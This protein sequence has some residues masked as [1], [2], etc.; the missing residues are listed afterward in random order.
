MNAGERLF[1]TN[2]NSKVEIERLFEIHTRKLWG[3]LD[4]ESLLAAVE[5]VYSTPSVIVLYGKDDSYTPELSRNIESLVD[6]YRRDFWFLNATYDSKFIHVFNEVFNITKQSYPQMLLLNYNPANVDDVDKYVLPAGTPLNVENIENFLNEFRNG[7]LS[8]FIYSQRVPEKDTDENGI[9]RVVGNTYDD[10]VL[11]NKGK[12]VL[13]F[14]C[15]ASSKKCKFARERYVRVSKKL[16]GNSGL[17]FTEIETSFN[18][19]THIKYEHLPTVALIPGYDSLNERTSNVKVFDGEFYTNSIVE[20]VKANARTKITNE[21]KLE[22]ELTL[23]KQ[24]IKK[25]IKPVDKE[26]EEDITGV[27]DDNNIGL[28]RAVIAAVDTDHASDNMNEEDDLDEILEEEAKRYNKKIEK[29]KGF[30]DDL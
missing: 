26:K 7:K 8:K 17:V 3:K 23:F 20:W 24:E 30:K 18:E 22:N 4:E 27:E 21:V 29:N 14:L 9:V 6:K 25:Q 16:T 5:P 12:D 10:L 2:Q 28:R 11:N 19:F 15:V 1:I 13:V